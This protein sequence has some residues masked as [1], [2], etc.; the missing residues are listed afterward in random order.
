MLATNLRR[1]ICRFRPGGVKG[2]IES[3]DE[4]SALEARRSRR[5]RSA[6]PGITTLRYTDQ[7]VTRTD[8][9]IANPATAS[10]YLL[11]GDVAK[12]IVSANRGEA[13]HFIPHARVMDE[14]VLSTDGRVFA[15]LL[16]VD[17][18]LGVPSA[19]PIFRRVRIP[20]VSVLPGSAAF[21]SFSG[22]RNYYHWVV[23]CL[24]AMRSLEAFKNELD[25]YIAPAADGFHADWMSV[26]GV[27]S[28]RIKVSNSRTHFQPD[29]LIAPNFNSGWAPHTWLPDFLYSR[30]LDD[31]PLASQTERIYVSRSDA[32]S[33]RATNDDEVADFLRS[34]GF[35]IVTLAGMS[36]AE[37]AR[38]F[39]GADTVVSIHGAGLTN[40]LFCRP[41]TTL[42]EIFPH[43]W[44]SLSYFKLAEI[45]CMKYFYL[46]AE[47]P[48]D[49]TSPENLAS[50]LAVSS[51]H[52][53]DLTVP[54]EKLRAFVE[55]Q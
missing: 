48:S 5:L 14:V 45:R 42:L 26:F 49:P 43:R 19:H 21:M 33:R 53:A 22:A 3:I 40:I 55:R 47:D 24:P 20:P 10:D 25:H 13:L 1:L 9:S 29:M 38:L 17:S 32:D 50:T 34:R 46:N 15:E 7:S 54:M 31:R 12:L 28:D 35:R 52:K 2:M 6:I 41:G 18:W 36:V 27:S 11:A 16:P 44:T 37:Q 39:A 8:F 23:E 4:H 30:V 51:A